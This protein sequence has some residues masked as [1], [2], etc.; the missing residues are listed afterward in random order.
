MLA[1][2]VYAA[3]WSLKSDVDARTKYDDNIFVTRENPESVSSLTVTPSVDAIVKEAQWE[4]D[5]NARI[6]SNKYS[7]HNLNSNDQFLDLTG[8]YNGQRSNFS[9]NA[10]Y[11]LDSSLSSESSDFGLV[12][13]RVNRKNRS[14]TPQYTR[15]LTERLAL[16]LSYSYSAV[17]YLDAG[18]TGFISYIAK[19]DSGSFVYNLTEKDKL[20]LSLQSLDYKSLNDTYTYTLLTS[21]FGIEHQFTKI[22]SA[23]FSA[24]VSRQNTNSQVSQAFKFF[25]NII[26]LTQDVSSNNRGFVLD[27]GIKQQLESGQIEAR[28]SRDNTTNS[29]GGLNQVDTIKLNYNH[30]LSALWRYQI[31]GRYE[32]VT[33]IGTGTRIT[34]RKVLFFDTVMSYSLNRNWSVNG[35]YRYVQRKF[36][37]TG[38]NTGGKVPVSNRIYLG[39][40]YNFP[41]FSTF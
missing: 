39:M 36:A 17:D 15:M 12:G 28:L 16:I 7:D 11:D 14:I 35:S 21:R 3:Q 4:G 1:G 32:D 31:R 27:A 26:V 13:R 40:T 38:V 10:N 34:D 18:N 25:G 41:T 6:R 37:D 20:T 9:L 33:A 2:R 22:L 5:L 24:G 29:F 23:D 30:Q 19:T 8:R